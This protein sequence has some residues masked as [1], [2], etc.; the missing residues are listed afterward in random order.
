MFRKNRTTIRPFEPPAHLI[1]AGP[2]RMTR[3]PIYLAMGV[4]LTGWGLWL[5]S[6]PALV[7]PPLFAVIITERFIRPEER[8]L[9]AAFGAAYEAYRRK[10]PRW[11]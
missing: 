2:Y 11:L 6:L 9:A 3:N 1:A 4:I 8:D 10:V 5:G 7:V